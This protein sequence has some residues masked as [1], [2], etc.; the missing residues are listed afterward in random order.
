MS[1]LLLLYLITSCLQSITYCPS[2]ITATIS[3]ISDLNF[4]T[5]TGQTTLQQFE[6]FVNGKS[7]SMIDQ[8]TIKGLWPAEMKGRVYNTTFHAD[9]SYVYVAVEEKFK[10]GGGLTSAGSFFYATQEYEHKNKTFRNSCHFRDFTGG[11]YHVYCP[12]FSRCSLIT[13][14]RR[15]INYHGFTVAGHIERKLITTERRIIER[16]EVCSSQS[17]AKIDDDMISWEVE[18][19]GKCKQVLYG[20]KPHPFVTNTSLCDSLR[21]LNTVYALGASHLD[22]LTRYLYS[23]PAIKEIHWKYQF[24]RFIR[25]VEKAVVTLLES[26]KNTSQPT[27]VLLQT[28]SWDAIYS[29]PYYTLVESLKIYEAI[30][31]KLDDAGRKNGNIVSFVIAPPPNPYPQQ[32]SNAMVSAFVYKLQQLV[33]AA[34]HV[35]YLDFY[36]PFYPCIEDIPHVVGNKNHFFQNG[37]GIGKQIWSIL[38]KRMALQVTLLTQPV[39]NLNGTLL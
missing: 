13:I 35:T 27:T 20:G 11:L 17:P 15:F 22:H 14:E 5:T 19:S 31:Q 4:N 23:C 10:D 39:K 30:I 3:P 36:T 16:K 12:R 32:C 9:K 18:Q 7:R 28:G 38:I 21:Q 34:K 33:S 26:I 6:N 37:I 8:M 25:E 2:S 24:T 1:V 29:H